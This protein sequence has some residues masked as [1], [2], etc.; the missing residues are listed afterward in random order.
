MRLRLLLAQLQTSTHCTSALFRLGY[1]W[2][3]RKTFYLL[4]T[5]QE[6]FD[7]NN[8]E[9]LPILASLAALAETWR[10]L[11]G[12]G[13]KFRGPNFRM[14]L[15]RK[16]IILSPKISDDLFLVID[17]INFLSVFCLSLQSEITN[18]PP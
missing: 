11:W 15:F 17:S 9:S 16:K 1:I 13:K 4:K 14:T 18:I 7:T 2:V 8:D 3:I 6:A 10:R 12:D 5:Y